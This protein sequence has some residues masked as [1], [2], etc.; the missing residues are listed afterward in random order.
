MKKLVRILILDLVSENISKLQPGIYYR[1]ISLSKS[2]EF[3][4]ATMYNLAYEKS[5]KRLFSSFRSENVG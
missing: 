5:R 2:I 1:T 4:A 3:Q